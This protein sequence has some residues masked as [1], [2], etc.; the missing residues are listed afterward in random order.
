M[1]IILEGKMI[2]MC[3]I[4]TSTFKKSVINMGIKLDSHAYSYKMVYNP[5]VPS[6]LNA[7][8]SGIEVQ[9]S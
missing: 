7:A 5:G 1:N 8:E 3:Q 9:V 2:F 6:I 4:V